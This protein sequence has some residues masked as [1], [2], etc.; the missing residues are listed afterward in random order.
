MEDTTR[1]HQPQTEGPGESFAVLDDRGVVRAWG[2]GASV[3]LGYSFDEVLERP[4]G[5]LLA[6]SLPADLREDFA[7]G[8]EWSGRVVAVRRDGQETELNVHVLPLTS[9]RRRVRWLVRAEPCA[10]HS[11]RDGTAP[12]LLKEWA[13]DQLD[14][15]VALCDTRARL[16]AMN[17]EMLRVTGR[18]E[19]GLLHENVDLL[20]PGSMGELSLAAER[21][22]RSGE[23]LRHTA[24]APSVNGS[25]ENLWSV[26]VS[27]LSGSGDEV[28]ALCLAFI[29]MTQQARARRRLAI[30][31]DAGD[32][33][34]RSLDVSQ[35]AQELAD[36]GVEFC[37]FVTVDLLDAVLDGDEVD[38]TL[39]VGKPLLFRRVAQQSVV[40][41]C[42]EAVIRPGEAHAHSEDSP[43]GC[44]L[45]SGQAYRKDM[46]S[47]EVQRWLEQ[48]PARRQSAGEHGLHSIMGVP[49]V[50]RGTTLGIVQF[51]RHRTPLP[52]DSDDLLLAREI[53]AR[54]AVCVDNARRYTRERAAALTL[55]RDL[56]PRLPQRHP[57][58]QVASR[59]L[60]ASTASVGGDWL[61]VIP[62]SG[63]RVALV[64]GDVVGH[65]IAAAATMGRLI[66]A[67]RTLADMDLP[68]DELLTRLDDLVVSSGREYGEEGGPTQASGQGASCM[69]AVYDPV[70]A[71]C[72]VARA[73]HPPPVLVTPDGLVETPEIPQGPPLGSGGHPFESSRLHVPSGTLLTFFTDGLLSGTDS[74]DDAG[75]T[76]LREV[77][78]RHTGS[79]EQ[80]CDSVVA[81][82]LQDR[83]ADDIA[84]LLV[85]THVLAPDQVAEW[86]VPADPAAVGDVRKNVSQQLTRWGL[87]ELT[88][89][90]ELIASELVTN[91]IRY[92]AAPLRLRLI[93][94]TSLTCEVADGSSAVP[95][96]RRAR[97]FDEGGRGLMVISQVADRWGSR[98][99]DDGKIIWAEQFL[100]RQTTPAD[101]K[102]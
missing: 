41:G 54:A 40:E 19:R 78:H 13:W 90:T 73:G 71:Q 43:P 16:V 34:G 49:L 32:R 59:Y 74:D 51:F 20:L 85:R 69:Y 10:N 77:L 68:P 6:H 23:T 38:P 33:V 89:T 81:S 96:I 58:V 46:E 94:E 26:V 99:H 22:T 64:V 37:D 24:R 14:I 18:S 53:T 84:L 57:A 52:F 45:R 44:A 8:H 75:P 102:V 60:P 76:A 28:R 70:T 91:A 9:V 56:L 7:A 21:V 88:F 100:G 95:R 92:G 93:R 47:P 27:P 62:L 15:P 12:A 11:R 36:V 67:V 3:L 42:P 65:G 4:I 101:G 82:V 55:Q 5:E 66:T 48:L 87:D 98:H 25:G 31:N 1:T 29:D 80:T 86:E 63:A 97:M 2:N 35:T 83:P 39:P 79:L 30:V 17:G 50:A 72:E 61:D